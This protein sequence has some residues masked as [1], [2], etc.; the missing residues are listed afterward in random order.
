M[1]R[2]FLLVAFV[3]LTLQGQPASAEHNWSVTLYGGRFDDTRLLEFLSFRSRPEFEDSGLMTLAVS[4]EFARWGKYVAWE[5]EGQ[6]VQHFGDQEHQELNGLLVFR[7]LAFPWDRY[8]DTSFAIGDGISFATEAPLVEGDR[9][10]DVRK[11]MNYLMLELT[12]ALPEVPHWSLIF[13]IHH[14]SRIY[15][16]YPGENVGSNYLCMGIRYTF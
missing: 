9:G 15:G 14:R 6:L 7:W 3:W 11:L 5:L 12:F 1:R 2:F 8:L 4:K 16:V 13:R 10:E